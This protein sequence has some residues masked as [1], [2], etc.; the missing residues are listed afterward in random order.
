MCGDYQFLDCNYHNHWEI[1]SRNDLLKLNLLNVF[2]SFFLFVILFYYLFY[3][4]VG[5][6]LQVLA[7]QFDLYFYIQFHFVTV[8]TGGQRPERNI[9]RFCCCFFFLDTLYIGNKNILLKCILPRV[10]MLFFLI[11]GTRYFS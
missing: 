6:Y 4:D 1:I 9:I 2:Y 8:V 11:T 7:G 3:P 10:H 5:R